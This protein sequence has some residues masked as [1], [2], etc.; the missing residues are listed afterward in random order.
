MSLHGTKRWVNVAMQGVSRGTKK[1]GGLFNAVT[2]VEMEVGPPGAALQGEASNHLELLRSRD[3]VVSVREM[4]PKDA[5]GMGQRDERKRTTAE[6]SKA[7][8][9]QPARGGAHG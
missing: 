1:I 4:A 7:A 6:A 5:S 2:S 9:G 8:M 3:V